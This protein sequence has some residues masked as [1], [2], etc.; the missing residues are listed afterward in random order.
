MTGELSRPSPKPLVL[1]QDQK[2]IRAATCE[3]AGTDL[4][5]NWAEPDFL[6]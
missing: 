1:K 2:S 5:Q 3:E 6:S 4:K